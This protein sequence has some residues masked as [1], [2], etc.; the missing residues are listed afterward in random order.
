[1]ILMQMMSTTL[2]EL[3]PM[4]LITQRSDEWHHLHHQTSL[5]ERKERE[6]GIMNS[7]H[8]LDRDHPGPG[9]LLHPGHPVPEVVWLLLHLHTSVRDHLELGLLVP[10]LEEERTGLTRG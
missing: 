6:A 3:T 4:I 7:I 2:T 1:M 5:L 10:G 9:E 8:H